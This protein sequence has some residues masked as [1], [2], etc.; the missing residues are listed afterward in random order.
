MSLWLLTL[1]L[2]ALAGLAQF[3]SALP[4]SDHQAELKKV[5]T[6]LEELKA[7]RQGKMGD[8]HEQTD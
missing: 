6:S 4:V 7:D 3:G 2:L 8:Y 1:L 5:Q